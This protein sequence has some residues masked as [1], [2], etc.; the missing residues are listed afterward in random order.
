MVTPATGGTLPGGSCSQASPTPSA[1]PSAWSLLASAGQLSD[2]SGPAVAVRVATG[3]SATVNVDAAPAIGVGRRRRRRRTLTR[4]RV[5][6]TARARTPCTGSS[7]ARTSRRRASSRTLTGAA[8]LENN[9]NVT[10]TPAAK[11][12]RRRRSPCRAGAPVR[13]R[14]R[15]GRAGRRSTAMRARRT[16]SSRCRRC[17]GS[18]AS[19]P[20]SPV[21]VCDGDSSTAAR[22]R[23]PGTSPPAP[24][25]T[26]TKSSTIACGSAK[27]R[28]VNGHASDQVRAAVPAA[29]RDASGRRTRCR[30][31]CPRPTG[32][33]VLAVLEPDHG[34][35]RLELRLRRRRERQD[36]EHG[37]AR[38]RA[39]SRAAL[40]L[41]R[42]DV[43]AA[44][45][46]AP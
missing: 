3:G 40:D 2:G 26:R 4:Q 18:P 25:G 8:P 10:G 29:A 15:R 31:P 30:A 28:N 17:P 42:A 44:F 22:H 39:A 12:G 7:R 11:R 34:R 43:Q 24:A 36:R 35:R 33:A 19:T 14:R 6:A 16:R 46:R 32:S 37:T 21:T 27:L 20:P 38:R 13:T 9:V 45:R 1:S 41:A 23:R 5:R